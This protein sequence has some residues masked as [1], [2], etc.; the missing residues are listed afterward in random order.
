VKAGA[1]QGR[2]KDKA[3]GGERRGEERRGETVWR[4]SAG[5][6]S[7]EK[8]KRVGGGTSGRERRTAP[9]TTTS[10]RAWLLDKLIHYTVLL[11]HVHELGRRTEA[12]EVFFFKKKKVAHFD[13]MMM[14]M[15]LWLLFFYYYTVRK[16]E[17]VRVWY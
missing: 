8:I 7:K 9:T 4:E 5:G 15:M 2:G 12:A 17:R 10:L 13:P 14:M 3:E 6:Q 11:L 16:R 1:R